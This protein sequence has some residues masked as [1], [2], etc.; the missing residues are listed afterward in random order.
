MS[1]TNGV[2]GGGRLATNAEAFWLARSLT[3][4][5]VSFLFVDLIEDDPHSSFGPSRFAL[6]ADAAAGNFTY[7]DSRDAGHLVQGIL[8]GRQVDG[9]EFVGPGA[10]AHIASKLPTPDQ[11]AGQEPLVAALAI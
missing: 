11:G 5:N 6:H 2:G 3:S 9:F 4:P 1:S 8:D 7:F 10:A